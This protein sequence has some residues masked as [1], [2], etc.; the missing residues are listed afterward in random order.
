MDIKD[1]NKGLVVYHDR[2]GLLVVDKVLDDGKVSCNNGQVFTYPYFL[3][4]VDQE[5]L[6]DRKVTKADLDKV[7]AHI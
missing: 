5:M 4:K 6:D 7:K 1:I 3:Q 2:L